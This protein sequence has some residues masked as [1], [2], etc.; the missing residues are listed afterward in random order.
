MPVPSFAS[1]LVNGDN[2]PRLVDDV[3]PPRPVY[4][5]S[6][7]FKRRPGNVGS[8]VLKH[9]AIEFEEKPVPP[10]KEVIDVGIAFWKDYLVKKI[11]MRLITTLF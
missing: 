9:F 5:W 6:S 4:G 7:L 3:A 2:I 10:H 1:S 8:Y 11:W